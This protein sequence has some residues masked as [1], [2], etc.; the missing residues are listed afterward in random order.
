MTAPCRHPTPVQC[1]LFRA[2]D[3]ITGERFELQRCGACGFVRTQPEP[4]DVRPY[5]PAGYHGTAEGIRFPWWVER[6]QRWLYDGRVRRMERMLG[7]TS[8]GRVLDIGCGPGLLLRAFQASGWTVH[9]T[10][11]DARAA[12]RASERVGVVVGDADPAQLPWPE[13][14]FDAVVMWH[15]LEHLREPHCVLAEVARVLRPGGAFLIATPN[16]G[17]LEARVCRDKWFHLD[18][19]R[20]L[21]HFTPAVLTAAL[22]GVG[23]EIAERSHLAL[24]YDLFSLVQSALNRLGLRQNLLY[25]LLRGGGA[26]LLDAQRPAPLQA[27]GSVFLAAPLSLLGLPMMLLAAWGRSSGT[28]ML[29]GRRGPPTVG[30]TPTL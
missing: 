26:R 1:V 21:H 28:I 17:C 29:W 4:R 7:L 6:L 18:V 15:V 8:P 25:E 9:G 10:E 16:F 5:Y 11:L 23:L 27:L 24:E 20:H 3:Y 14:H 2:A 19:P 22:S 30:R 13:S 12:R